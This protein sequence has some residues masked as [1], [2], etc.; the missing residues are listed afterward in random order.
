MEHKKKCS[1]RNEKNNKKTTKKYDYQPDKSKKV[2]E[3][4]LKQ[5]EFMCGNVD[6]NEEQ[7]ETVAEDKAEY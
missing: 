7:C 3:T 2:L 5:A 1:S 4:V 6:F